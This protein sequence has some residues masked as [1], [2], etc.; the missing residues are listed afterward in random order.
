[1]G[2]TYYQTVVARSAVEKG[3][4]EAERSFFLGSRSDAQ[5]VQSTGQR[6]IKVDNS[7]WPNGVYTADGRASRN[8]KVP[9]RASARQGSLRECR[10]E[11]SDEDAVTLV[12]QRERSRSGAAAGRLR[13]GQAGLAS[14]RASSSATSAVTSPRRARAAWN[15][16]MFCVLKACATCPD[17]RDDRRATSADRRSARRAVLR[18]SRHVAP[19]GQGTRRRAAR[20]VLTPGFSRTSSSRSK[21]QKMHRLRPRGGCAAF[22]ACVELKTQGWVALP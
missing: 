4:F 7:C 5:C 3:N 11:L 6:Y 10:E 19:R 9:S 18:L 20:L 8:H 1:M 13:G 12:W 22:P 21:S 14:A 15:T 16:S 2:I 17:A